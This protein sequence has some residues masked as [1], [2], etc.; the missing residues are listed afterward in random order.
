[1]FLRQ[2]HTCP[3]ETP[4]VWH[5]SSDSAWFKGHKLAKSS[6]LP[7][8]MGERGAQF[9]R[10][11]NF[12]PCHVAQL[13]LEG[14]CL[15]TLPCDSG[16]CASWMSWG[17]HFGSNQSHWVESLWAYSYLNSFLVVSGIG[18]SHVRTMRHLPNNLF[19][20]K[21]YADWVL[22]GKSTKVTQKAFHLP[23][24]GQDRSAS[25]TAPHW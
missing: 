23:H 7:I 3:L 9:L 20:L 18:N 5:S 24:C 21:P 2:P 8:T 22:H 17:F 1:M 6:Y 12:F 19:L 16:Y 10:G 4:Y 15:V 14:N 11:I 25:M 13:F